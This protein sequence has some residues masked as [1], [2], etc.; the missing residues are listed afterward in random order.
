[1]IVRTIVAIIAVV[2]LAIAV[3]RNAAV[4]SLSQFQPEAAAKFWKS[5]PATQASQGMSQIAL[6]ARK[7]TAIPEWAFASLRVAALRDPL[8]PE[9]FLVRGVQAQFADDAA[10]ALSAFKAAQWRNPR[11]VQAAYFLSDHYLRAG[12]T[13]NGLRQIAILTRLSPNGPRAISPYL[14][15]YAAE[16]RNWPALRSLFR[17]NPVLAEPVLVTLASNARTAPAV[18]ELADRRE[19]IRDAEWLPTLLGTLTGA[20]EHARARVIWEK[21]TGIRSVELIHD[22]SFTDKTSPPPFNWDLTSSAVGLA[23]RQPG[24]RLHTLYYGQQDGILA[25]QLLLLRPGS[26]RLSMQLLGDA[27]R[28]KALNW[29]IWCDK[30]GVPI[31]SVTLDAA[32]RGWRFDVPTGCPAQWLKLSGSSGELPQQ[33]D[34]TIANLKLQRVAPGA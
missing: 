8:A 32:T 3:I 18:L 11:S 31:S 9:P 21:A 5:H 24:G 34:A 15:A 4:A 16:P 33:L 25:T 27:V 1:M 20:G 28:G 22:A 29:S 23:E 17:A 10:T 19:N 12:D 14:V 7:G 6:A 13:Q 2:L 26:Y 30:A